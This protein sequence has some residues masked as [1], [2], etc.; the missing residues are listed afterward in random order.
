MADKAAG[1]GSRRRIQQ[2]LLD[3]LAERP[4]D[5]ITVTELCRKAQVSRTTYYRIYYSQREV[6]EDLLDGLFGRVEQVVAPTR[7][8]RLSTM[9]IQALTYQALEL[10]RDNAAWLRVI[11]ASDAGSLVRGRLARLSRGFVGGLPRERGGAG[12]FPTQALLAQ[13]FTVAGIVESVCLWLSS[14]CR[15]PTEQLVDFM[16]RAGSVPGELRGDGGRP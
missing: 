7:D 10:Y 3:L 14:G 6:L 9:A 5:S 1:G 11:L 16:L 15:L 12:S 2:A 8:A 4:L 13:E